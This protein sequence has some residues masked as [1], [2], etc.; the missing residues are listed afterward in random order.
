MTTA[1]FSGA[2]PDS[3]ESLCHTDGSIIQGRPLALIGMSADDELPSAVR[4][5]LESGRIPYRVIPVAS[6]G[7]LT[8][9]GA[10]SAAS[11]AESVMAALSQTY[12]CSSDTVAGPHGSS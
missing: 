8:F 2:V 7:Y 11:G 10:C 6:S 1:A 9:F 12:G 4:Q 5:L 3:P